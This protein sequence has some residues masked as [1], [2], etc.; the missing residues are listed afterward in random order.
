MSGLFNFQ[1]QYMS[2][3]NCARNAPHT[4]PL[5]LCRHTL[6]FTRS[7]MRVKRASPHTAPFWRRRFTL[8]FFCRSSMSAKHASTAKAGGSTAVHLPRFILPSG[9]LS[10]DFSVDTSCA[11][12]AASV[13]PV[14]VAT[15][16]CDDHPNYFRWMEAE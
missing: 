9:V 12:K 11:R 2:G 6:R 7:A 13:A 15:I 10:P 14:G 3:A 1:F 16:G 4:A 8:R 5:W